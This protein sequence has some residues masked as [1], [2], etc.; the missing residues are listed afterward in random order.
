MIFQLLCAN[1]EVLGF[2]P[3][4]HTLSL[5]LRITMVKIVDV[6]T[7][8]WVNI[9]ASTVRSSQLFELFNALQSQDMLCYTTIDL[10][11]CGI[12]YFTVL[13]NRKAQPSPVKTQKHALMATCAA[14]PGIEPS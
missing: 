11:L 3:S 12:L 8:A 7:E 5:W 9:S 13:P 4:G 14:A 6:P 1:S 2:I 10:P